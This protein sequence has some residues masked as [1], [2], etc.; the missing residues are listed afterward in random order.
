M[1]GSSVNPKCRSYVYDLSYAQRLGREETLT[2]SL[3]QMQLKVMRNKKLVKRFH[4]LMIVLLRSNTAECMFPLQRTCS[5][6]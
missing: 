5:M 1:P 2:N 6:G 3:S 4:D